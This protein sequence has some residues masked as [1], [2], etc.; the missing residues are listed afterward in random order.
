MPPLETAGRSLFQGSG[1]LAAGSRPH[2]RIQLWSLQVCQAVDNLTHSGRVCCHGACFRHMPDRCLCYYVLTYTCL[3]VRSASSS[4]GAGNGAPEQYD[5]DL[6][7]IGAG[8]GGTR[9]S[10]MAAQNHGRVHAGALLRHG[11]QPC[12]SHNRSQGTEPLSKG[13]GNGHTAGF[14]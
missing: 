4:N 1:V 6:F 7:T 13:A 14:R 11:H 5:F 12:D 2:S 3:Q 10:R 9:A 8:S